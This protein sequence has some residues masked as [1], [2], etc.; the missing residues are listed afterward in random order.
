MAGLGRRDL[1]Q[2]G[3]EEA[4]TEDDC[5][6]R[7]GEAVIR[8]RESLQ[9]VKWIPAYTASTKLGGNTHLLASPRFRCV[10]ELNVLVVLIRSDCN[11]SP[12]SKYRSPDRL[13]I[14]RHI[15]CPSARRASS[16][17]LLLPISCFFPSCHLLSSQYRVRHLRLASCRE[18]HTSNG[19][20]LHHT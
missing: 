17:S 1:S 3:E 12:A 19:L 9:G 6:R 2:D 11:V 14:G 7:Q 15:R 18:H 16:E 8:S 13:L 5:R 10:S 4:K 20:C